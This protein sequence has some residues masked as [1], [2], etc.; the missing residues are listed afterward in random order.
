M[1][2]IY[3]MIGLHQ[4]IMVYS[5]ECLLAKRNTSI[6]SCYLTF[7]Q[8]P[9]SGHVYRRG[10]PR[11]GKPPGLRKRRFHSAILL[12]ETQECVSTVWQ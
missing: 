4:K 11:L 12:A 10:V 1:L 9:V 3:L 7:K 8:L 5:R 2:F 6:H